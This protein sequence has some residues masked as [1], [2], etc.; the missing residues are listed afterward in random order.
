M[1]KIAA[2]Y[3][4]P[5]SSPPIKNGIIVLS[6]DNEILD[7]LDNSNGQFKEIAN[8]E[9]FNGVLIPGFIN[10]HCHLELSHLKSSVLQHTGLIG[11][12]N[13]IREFRHLE[14]DIEQAAMHA[15]RAMRMEGI[16]A[17]GDISNRNDTFKIK[18]ESSI[19]YFTFIEL[20]SAIGAEAIQKIN[21]GKTLLKE[22]GQFG[23]EGSLSPHAFYSTSKQLINQLKIQS[24]IYSLHFLESKHEQIFLES[25]S[26]P[27]SDFYESLDITTTDIINT[28]KNFLYNLTK[29]LPSHNN[30]LLVHN[31]FIN[32]AQVSYLSESLSDRLYWITCPNSNLYIENRLPELNL[33]FTNK[34]KVAI[35]TDSLSSNEKLSILEEMKTI[36]EH[37]PEI[38]FEEIIIWA[39]LNGAKA[40]N[41][42]N[43]FGSLEVGKTPG[44]N[45]IENFDFQ[46]N[47]LTKSSKIRVIAS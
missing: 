31:T 20:F 17:A 5:V 45:L 32:E 37:F 18:S 12:I 13:H 21:E 35:G 46:K 2:N 30:I 33:F 39:C 28:G 7:I 3:I 27:F 42:E 10:A 23:L 24:N 34:E 40:L 11:F 38:P 44:I 6:D 47:C 29:S 36:T 19:D 22:L 9:F 1:R 16:V 15:D 4:F 26:G 14:I 41:M 8:L 43:N 25:H